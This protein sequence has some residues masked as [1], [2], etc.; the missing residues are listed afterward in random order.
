MDRRIHHLPFHKKI[1]VAFV[2]ILLRF[3]Y[4]SLRLKMDKTTQEV[5]S[6]K[7]QVPCIFYFWHHNL[8]VA[9]MVR[10]M[11]GKR[12]M[13]GLMSASKDG[14][15][16]EALVRWFRVE[17]I[18]GSSSWRASKALQ[19]MEQ[20]THTVC[21]IVITPDGPK[22]P[23]CQSKPGSIKWAFNQQA[24]IIGMNF[25]MSRAWYLKS[26]DHFC[27][28]MP[29]SSIYLKARYLEAKTPEVLTHQIDTFL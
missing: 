6:Q 11:R 13:Y 8:F 17:A 14:A 25:Q 23:R 10:K 12:L 15:W 19:E 26:W 9:P 4:A 20:C 29:F 5:M 28:P 18:R 3:W 16:L 22:G 1:A 24:K 27:I 2:Y 21:D 7:P